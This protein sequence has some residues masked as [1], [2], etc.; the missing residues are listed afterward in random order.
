MRGI[1]E[2]LVKIHTVVGEEGGKRN[3]TDFIALRF[4][5]MVW[6][7]SQL[8]PADFLNVTPECST[9][10]KGHVISHLDTQDYSI[11]S[12][13]LQNT[14]VLGGFYIDFRGL[15]LEI[16]D[17]LSFNTWWRHPD[18]IR[19]LESY[20]YLKQNSGWYLLRLILNGYFLR[21]FHC[22]FPS[23]DVI[24][25]SLPQHVLPGSWIYISSDCSKLHHTHE[26]NI[27]K[28]IFNLPPEGA[29]ILHGVIGKFLV[30]YIYNQA[31]D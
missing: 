15:N 31:G 16:F 21:S 19:K 7:C 30:K 17:C 6:C 23:C 18:L 3:G 10:R 4:L 28:N 25:L 8:S 29:R 14:F 20:V 12:S 2:N 9:W 1:T 5:D 24:N 27:F 13:K 11:N 26:V 22:N